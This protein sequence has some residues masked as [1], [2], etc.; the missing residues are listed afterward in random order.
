MIAIIPTIFCDFGD[1]HERIQGE[2][3]DDI[4]WIM[5]E[6]LRKGWVFSYGG[7][8]IWMYC[9]KH[10]HIIDDPQIFEAQKGETD[11]R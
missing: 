5:A 1:C 7:I 3:G 10:K 4:D 8:R 2:S 9:P 6:A 11:V